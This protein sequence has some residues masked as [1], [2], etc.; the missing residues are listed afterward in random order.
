MKYYQIL[1]EMVEKNDVKIRAAYQVYETFGD[2]I[3][4]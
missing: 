3:E 4:F 1:Y 2:K